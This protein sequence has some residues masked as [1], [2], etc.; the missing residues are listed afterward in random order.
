MLQKPI[1]RRA[2][3]LVVQASPSKPNYYYQCF[4][5]TASIMAQDRSTKDKDVLSPRSSEHVKSCTDDYVASLDRASYGRREPAPDAA[6]GKATEQSDEIHDPLEFSGANQGL[7]KPRCQD[8]S[9]LD[10]A[11]QKDAHSIRQPSYM[12]SRR[13]Q[14]SV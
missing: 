14:R 8:G 6:R 9:H 7:S 10:G 1:L 5:S 11:P 13:R 4:H 3:C 12:S 2:A